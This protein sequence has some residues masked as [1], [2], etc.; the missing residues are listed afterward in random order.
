MRRVLLELQAAVRARAAHERRSAAARGARVAAEIDLACT[1]A[2]ERLAPLATHQVRE[3]TELVLLDQEVRF[4]ASTS[5][6]A[7]APD[8]R[9]DP[10]REASV[11]QCF[12]LLDRAGHGGNEWEAVQ[13]LLGLLRGEY[14]RIHGYVHNRLCSTRRGRCSSRVSAP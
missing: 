14:F 3:A 6:A 9:R 8:E 4:R 2:R 10:G 7:G 5:A 1:F 12:H 13:E 11:A